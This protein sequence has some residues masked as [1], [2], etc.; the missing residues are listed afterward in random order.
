MFFMKLF[1]TQQPKAPTILLQACE[2][3]KAPHNYK[4]HF[5]CGL[6]T[7]FSVDYTTWYD[8]CDTKN[9][10]LLLMAVVD[11]H[12]KFKLWCGL[13]KSASTE[14]QFSKIKNLPSPDLGPS[15]LDPSPP[16]SD[17]TVTALVEPAPTPSLHWRSLCLRYWEEPAPLEESHRRGALRCRTVR[18]HCRCA[19][20]SHNHHWATSL[21]G[22]AVK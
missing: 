16:S 20:K 8:L 3:W 21:L 4:K 11:Q 9:Q 10:A 15:S 19:L 1:T 2:V 6:V 17:H 13:L 14:N 7:I 18:L 12:Q 5:W 22:H